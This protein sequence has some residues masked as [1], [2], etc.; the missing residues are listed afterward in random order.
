MRTLEKRREAKKVTF[1]FVISVLIA[2]GVT[3]LVF[4]YLPVIVFE[5]MMLIIV[6][7]VFAIV[8]VAHLVLMTLILLPYYAVTKV[9]LKKEK[10]KG[11]YRLN[12]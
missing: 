6:G 10:S 7:L 4:R 11:G 12:N 3:Y 9:K 2:I 8:L 5:I 1:P